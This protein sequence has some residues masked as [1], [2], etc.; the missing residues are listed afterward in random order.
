MKDITHIQIEKSGRLEFGSYDNF[1]P[2]CIVAFSGVSTGLLDRL[3]A[4]GVI[5]SWTEPY[6]GATRWH[7]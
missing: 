7:G 4:S 6:E 5:R 2:E 1:D 3:Q